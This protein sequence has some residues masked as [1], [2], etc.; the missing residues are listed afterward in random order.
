VRN[1][2]GVK[3][4]FSRAGMAKLLSLAFRDSANAP[5]ISKDG[6]YTYNVR[7][8]VCSLNF[9]LGSIFV[10]YERLVETE[11]WHRLNA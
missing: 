11:K 8:F 3:P 2:S 6:I 9:L 5:R 10:G 4:S 7:P 1:P